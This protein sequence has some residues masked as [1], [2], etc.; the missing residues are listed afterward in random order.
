MPHVSLAS[1]NKIYFVQHKNINI[2]MFS[3]EQSEKIVLKVS[4]SY[5]ILFNFDSLEM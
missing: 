5:R 2:Y 4:L 3:S 1:N